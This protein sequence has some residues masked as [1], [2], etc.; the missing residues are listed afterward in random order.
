[1]LNTVILSLLIV[2]LVINFILDINS[3]KKDRVYDSK[4]Q[5]R[6]NILTNKVNKLNV[7]STIKQ[8]QSNFDTL[9]EDLKRDIALSQQ[10]S[11]F[12]LEHLS[13][14]LEIT[15]RTLDSVQEKIA[16]L[17]VTIQNLSNQK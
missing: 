7:E 6:I 5:Q 8:L 12:R 14:D 11:G 1:M 2:I 10:Q 16:E 4:I 3:R 15:M 13:K 17:E 9:E